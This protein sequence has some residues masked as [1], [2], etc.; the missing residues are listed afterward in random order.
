MAKEFYSIY[1][2]T[3]LPAEHLSDKLSPLSLSGRTAELSHTL[4][5]RDSQQEERQR[6]TERHQE[7]VRKLQSVS[8]AVIKLVSDQDCPTLKLM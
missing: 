7:T 8:Q 2:S 5:A 4:Q 3:C 6:E 1:L